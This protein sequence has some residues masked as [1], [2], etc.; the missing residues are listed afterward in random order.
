M[1]KNPYEAPSM[2]QAMHS[3]A[4]GVPGSLPINVVIPLFNA[5]GWMKLIGI[6]NI[7]QGAV[8]CVTI[9]GA[10]IGWLPLWLGILLTKASGHLEAGVA[11]GSSYE[12]E[13]ATSKIGTFFTIIGVLTLI[14]LIVALLY[15]VGLIVFMIIMMVVAG[16]A[17]TQM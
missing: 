15:V 1:E 5:K 7:I 14:N 17:A 4:G 10:V 16:T 3:G 11:S 12:L 2:T 13:Q 8:L 9:I 6:I